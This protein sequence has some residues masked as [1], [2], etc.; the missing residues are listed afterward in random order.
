MCVWFVHMCSYKRASCNG[1]HT[2]TIS[3]WCI[4]PPP[5][6]AAIYGNITTIQ[7]LLCH[8]HTHIHTC[9]HIH[10]PHVLRHKRSCV[11]IPIICQLYN[12]MSHYP[13][14]HS[15]L[16]S[17]YINISQRMS[18][19]FRY[20]NIIILDVHH[21]KC[22]AGRGVTW[23]HHAADAWHGGGASRSATIEPQ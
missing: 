10:T 14:L 3:I 15:T 8:M 18:N 9:A 21:M 11:I 2:C 5:S 4:T 19:Y 16:L 23:W 12:V 22:H 1:C 17:L 13:S 20:V 7:T 6:S